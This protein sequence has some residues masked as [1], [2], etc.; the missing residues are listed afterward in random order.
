[1]SKPINISV[2]DDLYKRVKKNKRIQISSVCQ[3][4]LLEAVEGEKTKTTEPRLT[5]AK[6]ERLGRLV[7]QITER[8]DQLEGKGKSDWDDYFMEPTANEELAKK[9][10]VRLT[11]EF[12]SPV[13]DYYTESYQAGQEWAAK[14]AS[15]SNLKQLKEIFRRGY[16]LSLK[17]GNPIEIS[18]VMELVFDKSAIVRSIPKKLYNKAYEYFCNGAWDMWLHMKKILEAEGY[19]IEKPGPA[20]LQSKGKGF[21]RTVH[22]EANARSKLKE[23]IKEE[24][25]KQFKKNNFSQIYLK[26]FLKS[27]SLKK[28]L[29]SHTIYR[30]TER[31][32]KAE[33]K[34]STIKRWLREA[35]PKP[36]SDEENK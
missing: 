22:G 8:I 17:R 27:E 10:A 28:L 19:E 5:D 24:A 3:T 12:K 7:D 11:E 33:V 13:P 20:I 16:L 36:Q 9:G 29:E 4:A 26:E 23:L 31:K 6:T 25:K 30:D 34:D 35:N 18:Y 2:P 14:Q 21:P 15:L 32:I 1:M